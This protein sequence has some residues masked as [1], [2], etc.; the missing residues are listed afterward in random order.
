MSSL[1]ARPVG[2]YPL[3]ESNQTLTKKKLIIKASYSVLV[4]VYESNK[5]IAIFLGGHDKWCIHVELVKDEKEKIVKPKGYLVKVRYDSLCSLDTNY[6]KGHDTKQ[7]VKIMMEYIVNNY[8]SVTQLSFNDLSTKKCDNQ[9]DVNLAVMTYLYS[10]ESWYEKNFCA[11]IS[12]DNINELKKYE[13]KFINSKSLPWEIMKE[14]IMLPPKFTELEIE[15][16]YNKTKS[17]KDF[18]SPIYTKIGIADFCIYIS[19]WIDSFIIKY[20]NNLQGLEYMMPVK[21]YHIQYSEAEY[22]R[23]GRR[24]TRKATRKISKDYK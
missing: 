3:P 8:P 14:T 16:L 19:P 24:F 18:F 10:E 23:G 13:N 9:N 2:S 7:L 11:F 17:W 4:C 6:A 5:K 22:Q 20:F 12:N 1:R 21:Y 15:D